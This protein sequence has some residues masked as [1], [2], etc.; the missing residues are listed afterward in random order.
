M[1]ARALHKMQ[2]ARSPLIFQRPAPES[3]EDPPSFPEEST[4]SLTHALQPRRLHK[5]LAE[6][7]DRDN[8]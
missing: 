7:H 6:G 8:G 1:A 3:L 4:G 2:R 5:W